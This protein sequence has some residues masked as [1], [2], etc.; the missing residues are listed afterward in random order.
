[1]YSVIDTFMPGAINATLPALDVE[2]AF[3]TPPTEGPVFR[4]VAGDLRNVGGLHVKRG[5]P[6]ELGHFDTGSFSYT[7]DNRARNYDPANT[8][9]PF[10]GNILPDRRTRG[11][12]RWNG[13]T[14][15]LSDGYIDGWPQHY[16]ITP[17]ATVDIVGHDGFKA[18]AHADIPTS[19]Y[20]MTVQQDLP[21]HWYRLNEASGTT[22]LDIGYNATLS[23]GLYTGVTLGS[24]NI[25]TYDAGR[26]STAISTTGS[27]IQLSGAIPTAPFTLEFWL[28]ASTVPSGGLRGTILELSN[29][30]GDIWFAILSNSGGGTAFS[31]G[32]GTGFGLGGYSVSGNLAAADN[33]SGHHVVITQTS[34]S[35]STVY[36]DGVSIFSATAA[37]PASPTTLILGSSFGG[38]GGA[39]AQTIAK[40]ANFAIYSGILSTTQITDHYNAG[41]NAFLAE[42]SGTRAGRILN[43]IGYPSSSRAVSTGNSALGS[44]ELPGG[45]ALDY[46]QTLSG[47][48]QNQFYMGLDGALSTKSTFDVV[49]R[50]RQAP[51]TATRSNTSQITFGDGGGSELQYCDVLFDF[52]DSK[53]YNDVG[54]TRSGGNTQRVTDVTSSPTSSGH[55]YFRQTQ[56]VTGLWQTDND[57]FDIANWILAHYKEPH[58]RVVGLTIKPQADPMNLWPQVLGREIGDRITVKYHGSTGTTL[59][60]DF[61]IEGIQ[62]DFDGELWI[63]IWVLNIADTQAYFIWDD[64]TYGVWDSTTRWAA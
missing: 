36:F 13:V 40:Y 39:F 26:A 17:D 12:A 3:T 1:M 37:L 18:I 20:E 16:D 7:L 35:T 32:T 29:G 64:T 55:K 42:T 38:T 21:T 11:L 52:E 10:N 46:L 63:T 45:K 31:L 57:A 30:N 44:Y 60:S 54:A 43:Y 14:Y 27:N 2:I 23:S 6:N 59:S 4:T 22:A 25:V 8:A 47:T 24:T 34:G 50:N 41:A 33:G 61:I 5:R 9:S 58:E 62:H 15:C 19:M 51:I 56:D 48:E 28:S 53:I 49:W